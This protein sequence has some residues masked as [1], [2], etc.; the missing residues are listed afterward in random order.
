MA[1]YEMRHTATSH[2]CIL[3]LR[4]GELVVNAIKNEGQA[5]RSERAAT[6]IR[7]PSAS[8]QARPEVGTTSSGIIGTRHHAG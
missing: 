2:I 3:R 4:I 8:A 7:T 6:S 1:K 5:R